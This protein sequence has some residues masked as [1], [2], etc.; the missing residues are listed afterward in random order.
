[1]S[2]HL[3]FGLW[4]ESM[5]REYLESLGYIFIVANYRYKHCEI[6]LLM[7]DS[8]TLV[9]VEVKTRESNYW[10]RAAEAVSKKKIEN[11]KFAVNHWIES[12]NFEGDVRFDIV[13]VHGTY[14]SYRLN[15]LKQA[16]YY[17]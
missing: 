14:S 16:F 17:F 15:H 8:T 9:V 10:N 6:D 12:T 2:K 4:G 1:M 11:L 3:E 7:L 5:A 13:E